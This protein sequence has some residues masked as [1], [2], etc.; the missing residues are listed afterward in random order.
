VVKH[1]RR[2]PFVACSAFPKCRNTR[3]LTKEKTAAAKTPGKGKSGT[4]AAKTAP[5]R[6]KSKAI[7]TDRTCPDC[8]QALVIRS[9]PRGKFLGCSGYPKCRHAENLP[10]DLKEARRSEDV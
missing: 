9:G 1:G 10:D 5:A 4:A 7:P 6:R 3:P 8:G 2:G